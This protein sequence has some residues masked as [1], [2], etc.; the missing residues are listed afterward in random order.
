MAAPGTVLFTLL[1][2][3]P[4][5]LVI[6]YSFTNWSS[7]GTAATFVGLANYRRVFSDGGTLRALAVTGVLSLVCTVLVNLIALTLAMLMNRQG[8]LFALYRAA[9]FYPFVVSPIIAGFLW[10]AIL[11][12]QG[13][14]EH[15]LHLLGLGPAPFL[16]SGNWAV[17]S[18]AIVSIWNT[19]G[20]SVV[21]Y[22][23]GLQ[24]IP[25]ELLEAGEIDGAGPWHR[26]RYIIRPML[27]PT[28][29]INLVLILVGLLR[30]YDMV[31]S[32]TGGGPAGESQT[33]AYQ[34]LAVGYANGELGYACA[35]AVILLLGT[36]VLA[37]GVI[38]YRW[39]RDAR[40]V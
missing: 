26:F 13:A 11:N 8:R 24:T 5:L 34:I 14:A 10:S 22:L 18:L 6:Y 28:V 3:V 31:L 32:L 39:R 2:V 1:L 7:Y 4:L 21:L 33:I 35:G 37:T 29:T 38:L 15:V 23:A 17:G 16:T 25:S 30:T 12:P 27:S 19:V 20:F 40:A 9:V 36:T